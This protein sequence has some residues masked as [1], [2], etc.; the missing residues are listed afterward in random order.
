M[1]VLTA[2][3]MREVDRRTIERGIPGLILM[4][5][6]AHRVLEF[7]VERFAPVARQ[8]VVVLCGKGNNGGDGLAI[9]R[10]L[11]T[12]LRPAALHVALAAEA[13]ELTGDAAANHAMLAACECPVTDALTPEM[14]AATIVVDAL[15][16]TGL[17]GSARGRVADWIEAVNTGFPLAKVVCVDIPSGMASDGQ[18]VDGP[19]MRADHTIT[20]TAPKWAHALPP[21]CDR[22][23][24]IVVAPVGSPQS[25]VESDPE[26]FLSLTTPT[27]FATVLR[28]RER[29]GHKGTYGS[30]LVLAGSTGKTG[31]AGMAGLAALRAGAGLVTVATPEPCVAAVAG[32]A[33]E[34]MTEP[35]PATAD[36]SV[37]L[38]AWDN[39][40]LRDLAERRTLCAVGPGLGTHPETVE[41]V[42][43]LFADFPKP[44]VVDADALNALAGTGF[45]GDGI[46][47]VLTPHPGEMA[48]LAD[49]ST[50]QVQADRVGVARSFARERQ[51]ILVLKGQ[52]TLVA[53]PD[54]RV[55]INPTG[56]PAMG[57]GGS[58]DILTGMLGGLLA[59]FRHEPLQATLA[60][61]YLHGLAGEIGAAETDERTLLATDLVRYLPE[62]FRRATQLSDAE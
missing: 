30:V 35:L 28:R 17:Q 44:L 19:V 62:A 48:R 59:Q 57:K 60:A 23:G 14:Q 12:R 16:G 24:E 53:A 42:R 26:A 18:E 9:A 8:R 40:R 27:D 39:G 33:P 32:H 15:L 10:H 45:R 5:N 50:E 43:R 6:A 37:A 61:V 41:V 34:L 7:L 52:R 21:W 29:A 55:W 11:F 22:M 51:L 47:R 4:E 38:A 20:F 54:G 25:L 36:G 49:L 46:T 2:A 58:G 1:R 3:Q 56:T 13:G 31:A